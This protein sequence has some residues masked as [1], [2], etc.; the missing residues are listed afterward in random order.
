[1]LSFLLM[2]G[3]FKVSTVTWI[4]LL[5]VEALFWYSYCCLFLFFT[6]E[7]VIGIVF[8]WIL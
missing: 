5:S 3:D 7:S 8:V 2:L 4:L 1:M 6:A